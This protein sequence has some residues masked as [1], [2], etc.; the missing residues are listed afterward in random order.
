MSGL[1]CSAGAY[2]D[3]IPVQ[4]FIEL[5]ILGFFGVLFLQ[6][7]VDKITDRAGNIGWL[8]GH[9]ENSPFRNMVPL[10]VTIITVQEVLAGLLCI[11]AMPALLFFGDDLAILGLLF[12]GVTLLNLF[13]GQRMAKDYPG[14][15]V[16]VP[17]FLL[18]VFGLWIFVG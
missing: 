17:Y 16:L 15:A 13:I 7:G 1:F 5:L 3:C 4:P 10:L 11:V 14:A 6:S 18:D 2:G 8:T 9:F 12:S